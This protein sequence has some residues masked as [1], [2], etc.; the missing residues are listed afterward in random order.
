MC[1]IIAI[2]RRRTD[3]APPDASDILGRLDAAGSIAL[4]ASDPEL[5]AVLDRFAVAVAGVDADLRGEP[6][7]AAMLDGGLADQVRERMVGID[8]TLA[9]LERA[10]DAAAERTDTESVNARLIAAKDAVWSLLRDRVRTADEVAAMLRPGAGRAAIASMLSVQQ[11]LSAL[12]RLEV[13]G[14]DSAGLQLLVRNQGLD[15]TTADIG[16]ELARLGPQ[17][18]YVHLADSNRHAPGQG[19]LDFDD[20]FAGLK[21]AGFNGWAAIEILARPD[22]DTAARQPSDYILPRIEKYNLG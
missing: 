5:P 22:A 7:L 6:G 21:K 8:V 9:G 15:L 12:D 2:V 4:E 20:V 3:Q 14:R 18:K 10:L 1:G 13:R 17:I 11:A 19:H 16:G